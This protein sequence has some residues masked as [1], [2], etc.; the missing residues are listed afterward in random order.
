VISCVRLGLAA[1]ILVP[2][3]ALAHARLLRSEPAAG[4]L[5]R[6]PPRTVRL[7][8]S[9]APELSLSR[10]RVVTATGDTLAVG[11]LRFDPEDRHA[12]L[13]DFPVELESGV[14][15]VLWTAAASDGHPSRGTIGFTVLASQAVPAVSDTATSTS[16]AGAA[17][18]RDGDIGTMAIGGALEAIFARWISFISIFLVIGV[19][20][21]RF[22]VIRGMRSAHGDV[23]AEIASVNAATLGIVGSAGALLGAALKLGRQS[24][25]MPDVPMGSMMFGSLWGW[26]VLIQ[27][28]APIAAAVAFRAAQRGSDPWRGKAWLIALASASCLAI[29]PAL[30]GHAAAGDNAWLAV[31]ADIVH[32]AVGSMWLGTLFVIVIVGIPAVFKTPASARPGPLVATMI[33]LFSPLGLTC[34][35]AVIATGIGSS[36][37]RLPTVRALWTTPYGIVLVLKLLFVA[38]LLVVAA[39]NWRRMK[40]LLTT[41]DAIVPMRSSASLELLIAL[42]VLGITAILVALETP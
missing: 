11:N 5:L 17:M 28:L 41:E 39:W 4:A 21:F 22:A 9:E 37:L 24:G 23:F 36:V 38:L 6:T 25:D 15:R 26:S 31:P 19:V 42:I 33:N 35:G 3:P 16:P 34:G 20:T 14:H 32:V 7:V 12:L 40:P 18:P 2:S 29:A 30:G 10:I 8:F 27:M 13:G 1:A